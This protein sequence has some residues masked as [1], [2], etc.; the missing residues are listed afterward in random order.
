MCSKDFHLMAWEN[1]QVEKHRLMMAQF[2]GRLL[3]EEEVVHHK[4]GDSLDNR[5]ENLELFANAGEHSRLHQQ[6]D[7][8]R[9][10]CVALF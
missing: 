6:M 2:L 7:R 8:R 4:N 10:A 3:K 5:I 9:K 1:G